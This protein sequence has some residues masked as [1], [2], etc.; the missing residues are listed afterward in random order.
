MSPAAFW[1]IPALALLILFSLA[2]ARPTRVAH[3]AVASVVVF[4]AAAL[5]WVGLP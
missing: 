3:V 5:L 1:W 4:V 2:L